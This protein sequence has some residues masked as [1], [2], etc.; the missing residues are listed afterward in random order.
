MS[1]CHNKQLS[2]LSVCHNKQLSFLSVCHNKQL[3]FLSVCHNKQL[4]FSFRLKLLIRSKGILLW[5]SC[6]LSLYSCAAIKSF[7]DDDD[8]DNNNNNNNIH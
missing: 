1:V 4:S 5:P 7:D 2:F 8:N 6:F 3:S